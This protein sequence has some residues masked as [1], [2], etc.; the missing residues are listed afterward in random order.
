MLMQ[1][2]VEN[3]LSFKDLATLSML[4]GKWRAKDK[5]LDEAA[6]FLV[7][8]DI[9]LLKCAAIYGANASGKSNLLSALKFMK[10]FVLNSSKESQAD[11]RIETRPFRLLVGN[12]NRPSKF[13][14]IFAIEKSLYQYS[15]SAN[16]E[17]IVEESLITVNSGETT[18]LFERA[19]K[20]ITLSPDFPEGENLANKTRRNALFLSV[21]AN[22]DGEISTKVL[23][24]FRRV[25]VISGLQDVGL[26]NYTTG[27]LETDR[28][29]RINSLLKGF[30]LGLDKISLGEEKHLD[31]PANA[32]KELRS[33]VEGVKV[34]TKGHKYP[35]TINS[36]HKIFNEEGGEEGDAIFELDSDESAGTQ[37]LVALSGPLVDTLEKSKILIVDEFDARLHPAITRKIVEI[38]NSNE[39]NSRNAQLIVAT[40]DT[41][42]LNK[43]LLRRDQIWFS[44][45]DAYGASHLHSLVEY[46]IRNDASFEK[47]YFFGKYGGIPFFGNFRSILDFSDVDA[48]D[49]FYADQFV[50]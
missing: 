36:H 43:E 26:L 35:R 4:A 22:F 13:E 33:I 18:V 28:R 32:S 19:G 1:F 23:R 6:T 15:F 42:L 48:D 16:V 45:K 21:C 27:C 47:D 3:F 29:D 25:S 37:K 9:K 5:N 38:F 44:E 34:L 2:S 50:N 39:I 17:A 46:K 12:E 30:D 41:N 7:T 8:D 40:H 24:W 20:D 11:E 31:L 14:I 49:G 10:R